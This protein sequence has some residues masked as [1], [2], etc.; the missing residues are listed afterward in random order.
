MELVRVVILLCIPTQ[1][2]GIAMLDFSICAWTRLLEPRGLDGLLVLLSV[3]SEVLVFVPIGLILACW[4]PWCSLN[5]VVI[6]IVGMMWVLALRAL[7]HL[8]L[9]LSWYT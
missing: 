3:P 9:R 4:G 6:S 8:T 1:I 5:V 7:V 2:G